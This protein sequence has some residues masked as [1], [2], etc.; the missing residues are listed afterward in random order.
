MDMQQHAW[1]RRLVAI[2]AAIAMGVTTLVAA[3]PAA[4]AETPQATPRSAVV[5]DATE[6]AEQ[7]PT[8]RLIVHYRPQDPAVDDGRVVW[9]W[10]TDRD[11][12]T[13]EGAFHEF[14]GEDAFGKVL[15]IEVPGA[16]DA[17]KIGLIVTTP[18]WN[19][20]GGDRFVDASNGTAEVWVDAAAPDE[21]YDETTVPEEYLKKVN[22][23]DVTVHYRRD[24][25]DYTGWNMYAWADG[26]EARTAGFAD[27]DDYG[28]TATYTMDSVEGMT[29]PMFIVRQSV[30]GNE[31]AAKDPGEGD[32]V[33]PQSAIEIT[34]AASGSGRAEIWLRSGEWTT[35]TNESV[36]LLTNSFTGAEIS[37]TDEITVKLRGSFDDTTFTTDNVTVDGATVAGVA[38]E[39]GRLVITTEQ[40]LD[41]AAGYTVSAPDWGETVA[42]AGAVVR[43]DEFDEAY[44]YDGDDLGATWSAESTT[45]KL[46]APTAS[47]VTLNTYESDRSADAPLAATHPMTRGE[48]GVYSVTVDG[49]CA[50]LAYDY[51]VTFADGTSNRSADPYATAAVVNGRRSVVL[52]DA[53]MNPEGTGER[54]PAF[55][56]ATDATIAETNIRD[57]SIAPNSGISQENKGKYLGMVEPGTTTDAGATS[58]LDYLKDLGVS[59]VQIMPM[60]DYGSVDETGDLSYDEEQHGQQNWGYDP[61]NYNVPEG[62]YSSDPYNPS[63]RVTELKQ[64]VEGLHDNGIRVIMDVVYNHVQ[65]VSSHPFNLVVPGYYFRYD[66]NGNLTNNSGCGND[67]ASERAMMRN[68]I[69]DS[70]TYWARNY[71][72]DGFRFDLMGLIDL[73]TMKEVR[74]ALDEI[75]PSII[76][77]GEGWD[78]NTTM[79]KSEMTT[80]PNAFELA[81]K[82]GDNGVAFFND[83]IRDALKGSVFDT[84]DTGFV[85]GKTGKE[86]LILNNILAC[87]NPEGTA[88]DAMCTNGT[89]DVRYGD[90]G[91]IVHYA[92]IHDN[93]TLYDK[94]RA[95]VPDDDDTTTAARAEL[96]DSVVYLSYGIP[97]IQLGQEF[98][99]TK[100]GVA[101][102]YNAGDAVNAI[103]W[104]RATQYADS[105]AYVKGLIDLRAGSETF[106]MA[107]YGQIAANT[108][109]IAAADG[110]VAYQASGEDGT[111]V[112]IHNANEEPA[113]VRGIEDGDYATLVQGGTVD[114]DAPVTTPVS[115]DGYEAGALS[116]TVL[117]RPADDGQQPGTDSGQ[118]GDGDGEHGPGSG[119]DDATPEASGEGKPTRPI[120][121]T[122]SAI[123]IAAVAA[124]LLIA[125]AGAA[126]AVRRR[127]RGGRRQ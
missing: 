122:G 121:S 39:D 100:N 55:G 65:D 21:T 96:A 40:A 41:P 92:E 31:W 114:L 56:K 70:V 1:R 77:L 64:M 9:V 99:R 81:S 60:Y 47:A 18:Q 24:D 116:T 44:A 112:V 105:V 7:Q 119:S 54:M 8:T 23:L 85:S 88:G 111:Y 5:S 2:A 16:Y 73:Q 43:T 30:D 53:Q 59:H 35:Y 27:P 50:D 15:D 58:G 110:V 71:N 17:D 72:V 97:A 89:A 26:V 127:S 3:Q 62:S 115:A 104:D 87:R 109:A 126:W 113:T 106:R 10:G 93:M 82:D 25:G 102:S 103:D 6:P 66:G 49:D 98:L 37:A 74:A 69:V 36:I 117:Y 34:D 95:S 61:L 108:K 33:I 120:A 94:L 83:S 84:A 38:V 107:D 28:M 51:T 123:A 14:T 29:R 19:K 46:W 52:S 12:A 124:V 76:V 63:A 90:A 118:P 79:D 91:Q 78:M 101:D 68:Y 75:D 4:H 80:Q 86:G 22:H 11:G 45:F 67:T 42:I 57:F 20:V 32:R 125:V 13:L 48:R